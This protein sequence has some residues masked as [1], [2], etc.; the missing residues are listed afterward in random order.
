MST[1]ALTLLSW[2]TSAW[3]QAAKA[4][5]EAPKGTGAIRRSTHLAKGWCFETAAAPGRARTTEAR[6]EHPHAPRRLVFCL[7]M[8]HWR[9][10][11]CSASVSHALLFSG[12]HA[13]E[14]R[15]RPFRRAASEA[16]RG[17]QRNSPAEVVV[18][19]QLAHGLVHEAQA[20]AE[21][22]LWGGHAERVWA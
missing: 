8:G 7:H 18:A 3:E 13:Q 22:G 10:L 15:E 2:S 5:G 17:Q 4:G 12:G 21:R 16:R 6:R 11:C 20:A 14:G 1:T 19:L 9:L